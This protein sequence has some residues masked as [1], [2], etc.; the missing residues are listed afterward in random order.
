M[1]GNSGALGTSLIDPCHLI[2]PRKLKQSVSA[3]KLSL[4]SQSGFVSI[5]CPERSGYSTDSGSTMGDDDSSS[6]VTRNFSGYSP[7]V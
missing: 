2:E 1:N 6:V 3:P 7:Q 5:A 4:S